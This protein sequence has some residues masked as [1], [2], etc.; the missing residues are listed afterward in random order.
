LIPIQAI[1]PNLTVSKHR[2]KQLELIE[3]ARQ[4]RNSS[5]Q[6]QLAF[7]VRPFVLC[8]LPLLRLPM[9]QLTYRRRNGKF[10]LE[11][12]A[13]PDFG[14]PYGQDRLIPIWI[15]TLAVRQRSRTVHFESAA[16]LLAFFRLARDGRYYRRIVD[17]F[18]RLFS[19]TIFFGTD[20]QP[21]SNLWIDWARFH[22]FDD[23]HLWCSH[24]EGGD[25]HSPGSMNRITLS[26]AF[27][28][29]IQRHRIPL[30]QAAVAALANAPGALDLY[31]WLAWKCWVLKGN[32]AR[33]PLF[34]GHGLVGQLGSDEYSA[35][36]FFR[37]KINKWLTQI[38]A[39]W[40]ECPANVS[41]DGRYLLIRS[42]NVAPPVRPSLTQQRPGPRRASGPVG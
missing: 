29:E 19:A 18:K 40:P 12:I 27:Y 34:A 1:L 33:V 25:A 28:D 10:F 41:T 13:H 7:H 2:L 30:E 26:E 36:R 21:G 22:F 17:G 32:A 24:R 15:A 42:S 31:I 3:S 38:K 16:Q 35:D 9:D 6:Q 37:R 23:M 39:L 5:V 8:G 11:L 20:D 4:Q 14:L